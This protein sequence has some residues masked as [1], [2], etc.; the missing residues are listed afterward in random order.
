MINPNLSFSKILRRVEQRTFAPSDG[1]RT[2]NLRRQSK[3]L[4][5]RLHEVHHE[6][7]L[8]QHHERLYLRQKTYLIEK[9]EMNHNLYE[10]LRIPDLR[11][12][13]GWPT[14]AGGQCFIIV[15]RYQTTCCVPMTILT[16]T[17]RVSIS[18]S[19]F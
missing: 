10:S 7:Q 4:R 2:E 19:S 11:E 16:M 14:A 13:Q 17:E 6:D 15:E 12:L 18:R 8:Q 5:A 1:T 3:S 9:R